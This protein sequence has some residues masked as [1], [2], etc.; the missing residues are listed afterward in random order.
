VTALEG[1]SQLFLLRFLRLSLHGS[2][3]FVPAKPFFGLRGSLCSGGRYPGLGD[4]ASA[5]WRV[6]FAREAGFTAFV[7]GSR[8]APKLVFDV[9][10]RGVGGG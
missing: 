9:H 1:F 5:L 3:A 4:G 6:V 10:D 7:D 8:T 2:A